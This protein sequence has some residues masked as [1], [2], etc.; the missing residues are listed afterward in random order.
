MLSP[1]MVKRGRGR[2]KIAV[3]PSPRIPA[4]PASQPVV[5]TPPRTEDVTKTETIVK[6]PETETLA[7]KNESP[8]L[9]VDILNENRNPSKGM[10][11]AYVIPHSIDGEFDV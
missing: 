5:V 8:K 1:R 11:M 2:P 7:A 4:T 3:L 9:W 10:A 6:G